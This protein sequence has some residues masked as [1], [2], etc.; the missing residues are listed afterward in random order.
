MLEDESGRLWISTTRG[1]SRF[2]PRSGEFRNYDVRDGLQS[3]EF[4]SGS[5]YRSA[6]GEMFFG[7]IN[8]FNAFFPDEI[9]FNPLVPEVVITDLRLFNRSVRVGERWEGRVILQR[10]VNR[11]DSL[12]LSYQDNLFS[13]EFAALHYSAPGKNRYAY[14]MEGFS[15][16]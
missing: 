1:L 4:N 8:G 11:T 9:G 16:A 2:D 3:N 12:E 13:L 7:G 5:A 6:A 15:D 14:T 10:P